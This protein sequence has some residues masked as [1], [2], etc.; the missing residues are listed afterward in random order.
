MSQSSSSES[1]PCVSPHPGQT[2]ARKQIQKLL[3]TDTDRLTVT[4]IGDVQ[5]G[6]MKKLDRKILVLQQSIEADQERLRRLQ[7]ERDRIEPTL[8][9]RACTIS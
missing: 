8:F 4:Q 2:N 3:K 1:S 6:M 5:T 9:S 7:Q